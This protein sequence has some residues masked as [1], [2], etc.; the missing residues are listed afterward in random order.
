MA[1]SCALRP[2]TD[3]RTRPGET[4]Q[5]AWF[6]VGLSLQFFSPSTGVWGSGITRR[7]S[8]NAVVFVSSGLPPSVGDVLQYVLGFPGSAGRRGAVGSCRGRVV[9]ADAVVIVTIDHYRLQTA[10]AAR[11]SRDARTRRLAGLCQDARL[12]A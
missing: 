10:T 3:P 7:I 11:T 6:D 12:P 8:R 9:R 2:E 1:T 4:E 5:V